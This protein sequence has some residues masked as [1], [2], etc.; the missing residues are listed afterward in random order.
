MTFIDQT[1]VPVILP[2]SITKPAPPPVRFTGSTESYVWLLIRGYALLGVTLGIYRFWLNTDV[3]R[4]LWSKTEV[5]NEPLEYTGTAVELLIGFLIGLAILIPLYVVFFV[6]ALSMGTAGQF[7]SVLS[8][9]FLALFGQYAVYRARRYRLTRTIYR[10][11][12]F[13]QD[14]SA[15]RYAFCAMF[16]WVM[17]VLTLGLAYPFMQAQLE[18]YKMRHTYYGNLQGAFVGSGFRLFLRGLIMW[19]LVFGPFALALVAAIIAIDWTAFFAIIEVSDGEEA[20]RQLA[21]VRGTK[22]AAIFGGVGITFS[23]LFAFFLYPVFQAMVM[24]WWISGLRLG[25]LTFTSKLRTGRIYGAYARF[26]GISMLYVTAIGIVVGIVAVLI[27][28]IGKASGASTAFQIVGA[29]ASIGIYVFAML[30]YSVIYRATVQLT[31]WR[32]S[33][34]SMELE[35]LGVLDT[36]KA[37]G[38]PSSAIGEGLADALNVGGI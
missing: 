13:H 32:H 15:V 35:N 30:G 20:F 7:A 29:V 21:R 12:R 14:G 17:I 8:V 26:I 33:V 34:Q 22:E 31:M 9:P 11:V 6:G 16:W 18:R 19:L 27:T 37:E 2:G 38:G 24:R 36:V 23:V 1:A 4:F 3:R 25:E 5:V 28:I 10:G